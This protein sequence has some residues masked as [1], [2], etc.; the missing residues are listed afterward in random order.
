MCTCTEMMSQFELTQR[1]NYLTLN[2]IRQSSG[3]QLRFSSMIHRHPFYHLRLL[4]DVDNQF[5]ASL[6]L[7]DISTCVVNRVAIWRGL[8]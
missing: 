3:L 2:V 8:L 4:S 5:A 6:L 7:D 1:S